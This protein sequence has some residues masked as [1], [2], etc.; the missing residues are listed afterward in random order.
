AEE[1][2]TEDAGA[3][4]AANAARMVCD[5]RAQR[6]RAVR[7]PSRA[8]VPGDQALPVPGM[9]SRDRAGYGARGRGPGACTRSPAALAHTMLGRRRT[10]LRAGTEATPAFRL[11]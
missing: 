6:R 2:L 3:V 5:A 11:W 10:A 9:R 4:R 1:A 7:G 8:A